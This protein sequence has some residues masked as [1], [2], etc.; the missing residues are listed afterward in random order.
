MQ[1]LFAIL[2]PAADPAKALD[3]ASVDFYNNWFLN[4]A[5]QTF[6]DSRVSATHF[7]EKS[8]VDTDFLRDITPVS[9]RAN[10]GMLPCF[11]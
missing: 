2:I 3:Y 11:A 1:N 8:F 5:P 4:F 6:R 10:P 9:L 7:V